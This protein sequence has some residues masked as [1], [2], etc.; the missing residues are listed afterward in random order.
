VHPLDNPIWHALTTRHAQFAIGADKAKRYPRQVGPFAAVADINTT[1]ELSEIVD[2]GEQVGIIG[3]IPNLDW[4]VVKQI[5]LSQY[6]LAPSAE[7]EEDKH[8]VH[9]NNNYLQP[10]LELTALVY[11]HYF[12]EGTAEVGD[13]FG[14]FDGDTLISMAG[15]RF[16][17]NGYQEISAICTH[18][19]YRGRGLAAR[20]TRHLIHKI[21]AKGDTPFLHTESDNPAKAMYEKLGFEAHQELPF[22]VFE[23]PAAI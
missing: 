17:M 9:L 13:Y 11:P 4:Q 6:V 20:L 2:P 16:A 12:R 18:P 1:N 15:I 5:T 3:V 7:G 22:K 23:M 19:D 14:I 21:T 8:A 10:M